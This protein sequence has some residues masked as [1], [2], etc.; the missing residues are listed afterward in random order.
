MEDYYRRKL[1]VRFGMFKRLLNRKC[2]FCGSLE[3]VAYVMSTGK[4]MVERFVCLKCMEK[5]R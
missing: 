4:G 1:L 2:C 3:A 5:L